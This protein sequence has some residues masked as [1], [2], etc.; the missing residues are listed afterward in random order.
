M[1]SSQV[2]IRIFLMLGRQQDE[3]RTGSESCVLIK[4]ADGREVK[5]LLAVDDN[6]EDV[7]EGDDDPQ[8]S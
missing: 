8:S 5:G 3:P 4:L 7:D 2:Q 1:V 6:F